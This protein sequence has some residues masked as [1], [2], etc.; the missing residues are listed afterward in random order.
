MNSSASDLMLNSSSYPA[1]DMKA[2]VQ[3]LVGKQIAKK[4]LPTWFQNNEILYP[5]RLSMEQCS[6]ETT[7]KYKT[8]IIN[9]GRGIDL[10]GGFGV[11]TIFL[12]KQSESLIYCERNEDLA[13]LVNHNFKALNQHN[14]EVHVGDGVDY[15]KNL[16][17]IDW[18]YVDPSRRKESQRIY[19][20]EDCEPNVIDLIGLFFDKAENVLIKTA[21]L[22][23]I[24][25]TLRDLKSVKEV[26]VIA[27]NNDCKEV[28]YLLEKDFTGETQIFCVNL[29]KEHIEEFRF[30]LS[31]ERK[32]LSLYSEPLEYIYE[33]NVAIMKAGAFKS[34]ASKHELY[35]LHKHSHL[36][37]S[38]KL[39]SEFPGR[40]FNVK[41]VLN[42][43]KKSLTKL[44]KKANI[45]CRNYPHKVDVLKKKLKINDGGNDYIFATTLKGEKLKLIVCEKV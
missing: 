17:K 16:K 41:E 38:Q 33:A 19:R 24:Q 9:S 5:N 13:S 28:L 2:I 27:V 4:K 3:Q 25:K 35:K 43:D 37:T 34:I 10:T 15:L 21:P 42:P 12:S 1:W 6:S 14:C 7:A 26:H 8:T 18:I 11:D 20:L 36:Y 29:K 31:E 30:T 32:A 22:L 44:P 45:A 23:D 39:I 40:R